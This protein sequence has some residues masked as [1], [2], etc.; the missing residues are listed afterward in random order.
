MILSFEI[1]ALVRALLAII[2]LTLAAPAC[3]DP[4]QISVPADHFVMTPGGVDMRTGRYGYSDTDLSIG[5]GGL[6]LTR[7]MPDYAADHAN[8]FGNFSDNWDI[9]LVEMRVDITHH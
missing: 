1:R 4:A 5:G 9:M 8:P 3:A 2:G 7:I 6:S